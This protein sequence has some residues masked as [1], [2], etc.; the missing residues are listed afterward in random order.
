MSIIW[1]TFF[2]TSKVLYNFVHCVE[3]VQ[4][5][6]I[7]ALLQ[8]VKGHGLSLRFQ[9]GDNRKQGVKEMDGPHTVFTLKIEGK[10]NPQSSRL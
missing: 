3:S 4:F 5:S 8:L 2:E 9:E 6:Q 10:N 1:L 7:C